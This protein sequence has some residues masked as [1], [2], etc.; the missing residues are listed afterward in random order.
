MG[1]LKEM[2]IPRSKVKPV[3]YIFHVIVPGSTAKPIGQLSLPVTFGRPDNF[4]TEKNPFD[5]VDFE[6]A[7]NGI[8]GNPALAKFLIATHYC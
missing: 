5:V 2:Q 4:R 1:A 8:L 6:I 7:Y 3:K